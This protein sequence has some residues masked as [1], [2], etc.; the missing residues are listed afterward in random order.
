MTIQPKKNLNYLIDPTFTNV[1]KLFFCYFQ[2]VI[3]M[4]IEQF[5][6]LCT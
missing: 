4:I 5:F 1:K 2:E 3:Y 6:T